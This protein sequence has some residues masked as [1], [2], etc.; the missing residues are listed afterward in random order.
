MLTGRRA[1]AAL[2]IFSL[3]FGALL[4]APLAARA[5]DGPIVGKPIIIK[6]PP[7]PQPKGNFTPVGAVGN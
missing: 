6:D 3:A 1:A 5:D 4:A 7:K 2:M